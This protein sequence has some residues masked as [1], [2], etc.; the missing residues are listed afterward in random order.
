PGCHGNP[1]AYARCEQR[2][3]RHRPDGPPAW[4]IGSV[5][6]C[7]FITDE[8][9][10]S[11]ELFK[12]AGKVIQHS[13]SVNCHSATEVWL[14]RTLGA[15]S[16][17]DRFWHISGLSDTLANVCLLGSTGLTCIHSFGL[18]ATPPSGKVFARKYLT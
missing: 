10:R 17:Q 3:T 9:E 1:P 4:P 11:I 2:L 7:W 14:L 6:R 12:E 5:R 16:A 8:T 18:L 13:R 15:A